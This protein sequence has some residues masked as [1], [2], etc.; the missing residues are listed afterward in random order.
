[1]SSSHRRATRA[2]TVAVLAATM[3][4]ACGSP[5]PSEIADP[6]EIL[7]QAVAATQSARSVHYVADVSGS[8]ALDPTGSG[9]PIPFDLK[10]TK[11]EGDVDL[12]TGNA[13]SALTF[14][15]L[16]PAGDAIVVGQDVYLR[17]GLLGD[18][19]QKTTA[20]QSP[21]GIL[22][23]PK[24]TVAG[25]SAALGQLPSPPVKDPDE[26]CGQTTCYVVTVDVPNAGVAGAIGGAVGGALGGALG[27]AGGG[28]GLPLPS[29]VPPASGSEQG[30]VQ[31]WARRDDLRP[32]RV[33][34][35][36]DGGAS[37]RL[38]VDV[39][40][41]NWDAPVSIAAPPPDQVQSTEPGTSGLGGPPSFSLPPG[42][43]PSPSSP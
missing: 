5:G 29:N 12:A 4:A 38:V 15:G 1:M 28:S 10:G 3:L 16:G 37:G 26:S 7:R 36:A 34:I 20:A 13:T 42:L 33:V 32:V 24:A 23:D 19:W 22:T 6:S 41:T 43:L 21:L 11:A 31:L 30:T 14:P 9:S 18:T 17:V 2:A 25:L 35:T 27:G 8:V 40:L 39:A